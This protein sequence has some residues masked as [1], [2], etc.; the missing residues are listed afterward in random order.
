[1][2]GPS[3]AKPRA[4]TLGNNISFLLVAAAILV[5]Q[6]LLVQFG[7]AVFRTVPLSL[8][9]WGVLLAATSIVF[10]AGEIWRALSVH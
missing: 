3:T 9:D 6:V 7:G 8:A 5:G 2:N 4:Q 1:M 10:W